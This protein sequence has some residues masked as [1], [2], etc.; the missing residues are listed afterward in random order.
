MSSGFS[1]TGASDGKA[2]AGQ[3]GRSGMAAVIFSA[4][5]QRN[6]GTGV[7]SARKD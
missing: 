5:E 4:V 2:E 7:L 3:V 6:V 1:T